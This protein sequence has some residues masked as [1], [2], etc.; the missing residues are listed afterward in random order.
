MRFSLSHVYEHD[1]DT[2]LAVCMDRHYL[3]RKYHAMGPGPVEFIEFGESQDRFRATIQ[4]ELPGISHK[5]VPRIARRF[6]R[7]SYTLVYTVEWDLEGAEEKSGRMNM[8]IQD[9]P[10]TITGDL[11][12]LPTEEGCAKAFD[13]Q[14]H[15]GIPV[16][17]SKVSNEA[18]KLVRRSLDKE[19]AFSRQYLREH[20]RVG[21]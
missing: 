18:A 2:V 14:I 6:V 5:D 9:V 13:I 8:H 20:V 15:S 10:V 4:R 21:S 17:G 11:R 3:E 1:A 19:Y 7:D 16:I 12:L